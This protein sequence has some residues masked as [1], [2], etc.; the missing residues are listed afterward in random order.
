MGWLGAVAMMKSVVGREEVS[1]LKA[2]G[3]K[4]F[5]TILSHAKYYVELC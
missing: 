1:N 5:Y 4:L 2:L 3:C